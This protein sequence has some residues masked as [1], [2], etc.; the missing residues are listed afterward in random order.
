MR[1]DTV[2]F[3]VAAWAAIRAAVVVMVG[4][5]RVGV[6]GCIVGRAPFSGLTAA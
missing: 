4:I 3:S 2:P 1:G 5:R 6:D